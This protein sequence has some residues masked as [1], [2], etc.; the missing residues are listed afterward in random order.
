MKTHL[1]STGYVKVTH[2]WREG[3]GSGTMRLLNT[4]FD[5]H[6]TD[7]L[8]IYCAVIEH[9]EGLIVVDTGIL[10]NANTSVYFPPQVRLV[11]RA[12]PFQISADQEI[13]IQMQAKGL[14]P[15]DVR[16]VILTHLHQDHDGGLGYFPNAE[17]IVSRPE[18]AATR[19]FAGRMNGYMTWRWFDGFKPRLVDFTDGVYHSFTASQT[20]TRA[21]DVH[22]VPTPGHSVGHLSVVVEQGDHA[23]FIAGDVAYTEDL[24]LKDVI[25]GIG[26][27]PAAQR[28]SHRRIINLAAQVPLVF[29]PSHDP[30][31]AHRL[32]HRLTIPATT[33]AG[34]TR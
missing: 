9:P 22:I 8:P 24:L 20:L 5:S 32:E 31:A 34:I 27:D 16:W 19:G 6:Q 23:L 30:D 33:Q 4:L 13:G 11:Q 14:N 2:N 1:I 7:W 28:D 25:D 15:S 12:A 10:A 26:P 3:K 17:F 29:L 18:W 21:G